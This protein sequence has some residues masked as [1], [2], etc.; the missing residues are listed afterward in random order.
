MSQSAGLTQGHQRTPVAQPRQYATLKT[1]PLADFV[2]RVLKIEK[3]VTETAHAYDL[4]F[5]FADGSVRVRAEDIIHQ[6]LHAP[7]NNDEVTK[8]FSIPRETFCA[9]LSKYLSSN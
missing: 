4:L 8:T 6:N 1:W 5:F 9:L 2:S 7:S 3:R